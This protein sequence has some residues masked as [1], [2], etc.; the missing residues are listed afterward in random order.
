MDAGRCPARLVGGRGGPSLEAPRGSLGGPWDQLAWGQPPPIWRRCL[1][2]SYPL[3]AGH[4]RAV[5]S[6]RCCP[7]ISTGTPA[8]PGCS[9]PVPGQHDRTIFLVFVLLCL[10]PSSIQPSA[11]SFCGRER[12]STTVGLLLLTP[13]SHRELTCPSPHPFLSNS[14]APPLDAGLPPAERYPFA[15]H[16]GNLGILWAKRSFQPT[17]EPRLVCMT[18]L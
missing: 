11:P 8:S 5:A 17:R 6:P 2:S 14:S 16:R 9:F 18:P 10:F 13:A 3:L 7:K 1:R 12:T 15:W 4:L